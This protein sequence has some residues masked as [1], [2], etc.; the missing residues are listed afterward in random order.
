MLQEAKMHQYALLLLFPTLVY[1]LIG[2]DCGARSLNITTLSLLDVED[3]EMPTH[4][5]NI[6]KRYVQLLQLNTFTDTRVIQ[7]KLEV[8]RTVY[9]CG[10][11]S[12]VSI[13]EHGENEYIYEM[14]REKCKAVHE[15]GILRF[16][17]QMISGLR[18]NQTTTHA[19]TYA[20]SINNDG[21]CGGTTYTDPFGSW[22]NVVVQGTLKITLKDHV[23]TVDLKRNKIQLRSGTRCTL[24]DGYCIDIEGGYTFWDVVPVDTCKFN[25][26]GLLYEGLSNKIYDPTPNFEQ[27]VYSLSTDD[28][29]FAL[30]AKS[31]INVCGYE[32]YRTE[33]PKL[34]I[35]ETIKGV[36]FVNRKRVS[37][38]NLDIFAYIN[39]KFVF[40]EKHIKN[41][42]NRLYE[43]VVAERCKQE[44]QIL[45]NALSIASQSPDQ[46]AYDLMKGPGYMAINSGEVIHVIKCIPVEVRVRHDDKCYEELAVIKNNRTMFMMPKTHVLKKQGTQ[47]ECNGLLPNYFKIDGIWYKILPKLTDAKD[48]TT[49]HPSAKSS[50]KY[51]DPASLATSGIYTEKDLDQLR[52][53]I[54]FPVEQASLL[55]DVAREMHGHTII[56]NEGAISKLL[57]ENTIEKIVSNAWSSMWGKFTTFG[58]VSAGIFSIIIIIQG[59]K[60]VFGVIIK[61]YALHQVYGW[62]LHLLGALW[63]SLATLFLSLGHRAN[64]EARMRNL[65]PE[66]QSDNPEVRYTTIPMAPLSPESTIPEAKQMMPTTSKSTYIVTQENSHQVK[67][68]PCKQTAEF[69]F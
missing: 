55:N 15:T 19:L 52:D 58:S 66:M 45:K 48:P 2:Y 53:R 46:F 17:N 29:T 57:N 54:M 31:K 18:V 3:C 11:H 42:I 5:L 50:W 60:M 14:S 41:Q 69:T 67:L 25:D 65:D 43:D 12:H 39:S 35:F 61:G 56:D 49:L 7:C 63:G 40:V 32:V 30:I 33:H 28:V 23:A 22:D 20:G 26:Y 24:T 62:S 51:N 4:H 44:R 21:K 37:I 13:M 16:D 27:T 47:I 1:S 59:I 34:F 6:T 8:H 10:M 36:S 38:D 9:Y 64:E 68:H